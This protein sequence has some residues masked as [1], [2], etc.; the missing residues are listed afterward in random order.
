MQESSP[1]TTPSSIASL[2]NPLIWWDDL[3]HLWQERIG[4]KD[5]SE[6]RNAC[7]WLHSLGSL[8]Y[9]SPR[10]FPKLSLGDLVVCVISLRDRF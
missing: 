6:L 7:E 2:E 8:V 10:L 3:L 5:E 4:I 9:F 1:A